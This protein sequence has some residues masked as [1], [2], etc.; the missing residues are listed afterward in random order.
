MIAI[1]G[2]LAGG[3]LVLLAGCTT[4]PACR[5]HTQLFFGAAIAESGAQV[6]EAVWRDFVETAILPRFPDGFTVMDAA[7]L[8]RSPVTGQA[9][10]EPSRVLLV[11]HPDNADSNSK[12]D[13]IAADYKTRFRQE[14]VLRL[15]QCGAYSF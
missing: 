9:V 5:N 1:R 2:S 15:D 12:L 6:D 11:L 7:G 3:L 13:A 14:S 8:W 4:A 10:R